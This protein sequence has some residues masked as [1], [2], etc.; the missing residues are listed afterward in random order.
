MIDN[1]KATAKQME[2]LAGFLNFL[3]RAIVPGRAFTRRMYAKFIGIKEKL[4]PHY[5]ITIDREFKEDCK[6]WITFL[7]EMMEMTVCRPFIDIENSLNAKEL[8]FFTDALK[9]F[10]L[11]FGCLFNDNWCY[12]QWEQGFIQA[13]EKLIYME[14]LE[15]YALCVGVFTWID[16]LTVINKWIIVFCD[17]LSVVNMI[18][19]TT[20]GSKFCMTLI[21]KFI[22]KSFKYNL[23]IFA[24]HIKG[25]HNVLS[26]S[27]S[28]LKVNK[29]RIHA[30]NIDWNVQPNPDEPSE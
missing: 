22:L 10:E 25:K 24:H 19:H 12:K 27:L 2:R 9:N 30:A 6:A 3:N 21:W 23:R 20:S 4:K 17:N 29:F 15:L 7:T 13:H 26:D 14:F 11:G 8:G 1:R 5:Q 28:R 16:Q 18:N